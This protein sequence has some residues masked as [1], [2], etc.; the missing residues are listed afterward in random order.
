[1]E[2]YETMPDTKTNVHLV[3]QLFILRNY[4]EEM[5]PS[6]IHPNIGS[7]FRYINKNIFTNDYLSGIMNQATCRFDHQMYKVY[8][9]IKSDEVAQQVENVEEDQNDEYYSEDE[10]KGHEKDHAEDKARM[11]T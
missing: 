1:M 8:F 2:Y 11:A 6:N 9:N 7:R 4:L 10:V 3:T 5:F